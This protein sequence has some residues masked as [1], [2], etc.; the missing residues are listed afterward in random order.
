MRGVNGNKKMN[1]RSFCRLKWESFLKREI[2]STQSIDITRIKCF[3]YY[4]LV[5]KAILQNGAYT[6]NVNKNV[7]KSLMKNKATDES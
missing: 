7:N 4:L 1:K 2:K 5:Q 6:Q 3:F